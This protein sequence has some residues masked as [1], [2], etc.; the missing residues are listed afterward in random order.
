M[1]I[2]QRRKFANSDSRYPDM[3]QNI[4]RHHT[5]GSWGLAGCV[6]PS[7]M[8]Y[9]TTRGGPLVGH[10]A[11]VLQG[12]PT[13]KLLLTR[14]TE[15]ELRDLA[16]NAM[17]SSVVGV[18]LVA[19]IISACEAIPKSAFQKL[20]IGEPESVA[21]AGQEGSLGPVENITFS[22]NGMARTFRFLCR[23]AQ[24]S[25]QFCACEGQTSTAS[26]A[27]DIVECKEC[28]FLACSQCAGIPRHSYYKKHDRSR[29]SPSAF[30]QEI[31]QALPMRLKLS[32]R[33]GESFSVVE[34]H[35]NASTAKEK[36]DWCAFRSAVS[37]ALYDEYRFKATKRFQFWTICYEGCY[38]RLELEMADG[39]AQWLLYATPDPMLPA[40]ANLRKTL[41]MPIA[42]T[43][44]Q[45]TSCFGG[46]WQLCVPRAFTF[47]INLEGCGSQVPSWKARLGLAQ[48]IDEKV[49]SSWKVSVIENPALLE[50]D[51]DG[52]YR[53]LPLCGTANSNLHVRE[54]AA[55][56]ER[57]YLFLDPQRV[58]EP[59]FDRFVIASD[60]RRLRYGDHRRIDVSIGIDMT[61]DQNWRPNNK[62]GVQSASCTAKGAWIDA[63]I[64]L[65]AVSDTTD[66]FQALEEPV[67]VSD[68]E[69][70]GCRHAN[71]V[72]LRCTFEM[73]HE[74]ADDRRPGTW[75][76]GFLEGVWRIVDS[77][78]ERQVYAAL[79]WL[80]E[81]VRILAGLYGEWHEI[82][83]EPHG[84]TCDVCTPTKPSM[85]WKRVQATKACVKIVPFE[86]AGEAGPYERKVKARPSPLTTRVRLSNGKG[87]LEVW[88]NVVALAH[89]AVA[90]L[91]HS[92]FDPRRE[93]KV[94]W[95]LDTAY[96]P[97]DAPFFAPLHIN[98]NKTDTA[99]R[100]VF[101]K[102]K[103][104]SENEK[105]MLRL[106]QQRSLRWMIAQ[107]CE[108]VGPFAEEEVEEFIM[109][110]LGWRLLARAE[111]L[112]RVRGGLLADK[113]GYGKT[114]TTL[115]LIDKQMK[116]KEKKANEVTLK[117]P[118]QIDEAKGYIPLH[119]TLILVPYLL[120]SQWQFEIEDF[121]GTDCKVCVI[122]TIRDI[123]KRTIADYQSADIILASHTIFTND[124][125]L[126]RMSWF[127]AR[128]EPHKK[129]QSRA[130]AAW[131]QEAEEKIKA[132]VE[133]LKDHAK[134]RSLPKLDRILEARLRDA[135][136]DEQLLARIP[137]KRLKGAAYI[138]S[139]AKASKPTQEEEPAAEE[140]A[141]E[142]PEQWP[143]DT[144]GLRNAKRCQ[145]FVGPLLQMFCF[146]RIVVDEYTYVSEKN[147]IPITYLKADIRWILSGTP[148]VDGFE[149]VK[150]AATLLGLNL[151]V[152]DDSHGI[153]KKQKTGV[154]R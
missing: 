59:K 114:I 17:S 36:E 89:R 138:K 76:A 63:D 95:K 35:F 32:G 72:A 125:Y 127:A 61:G 13:D 149:G 48:F 67:A 78:N 44:L 111:S 33:V 37:L 49:W 65:M 113:V 12:I 143:D 27:D 102:A 112:H 101:E 50:L 119:A 4:D 118:F 30:R 22:S 87:N 150:H 73:P 10:E 39:E 92:R 146:A 77:A 134:T 84:A 135:E 43:A 53:L 58:G 130:L 66:T 11:L 99:E 20:V 51:V 110:P 137:S 106:E 18:A 47:E 93:I 25:A 154:S 3:S 55:S 153:M 38:S 145:D 21:Q 42:R 131:L 5:T 74:E 16:G 40:N 133:E 148:D 80:T 41:E 15:S 7:G 57:K 28:L 62:A 104:K 83:R 105:T 71:M 121:L 31:K 34:K 88:I 54:S 46:K 141:V 100:H 14:E 126:Q 26:R 136:A 122:R 90:K 29:H 9:S 6:T 117:N 45:S 19:A 140:S 144:F 97:D 98:D 116:A 115:A 96:N 107:E 108:N 70:P 151:G 91:V 82:L 8:I 124:K 120:I 1:P 75:R 79:A 69:A 2:S 147:L 23:A 81:R 24:A 86:D 103:E 128:P 85:K 64:S 142:E 94:T 56:R 68:V 132:H 123:K 60:H 109:G 129:V 152:D 52:V 139:K